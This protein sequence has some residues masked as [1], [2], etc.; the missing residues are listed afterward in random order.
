MGGQGV[1]LAL[2][3]DFDRLSGQRGQ[4]DWSASQLGRG[5]MLRMLTLA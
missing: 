1:V 3:F 2:F 5:E 4:L